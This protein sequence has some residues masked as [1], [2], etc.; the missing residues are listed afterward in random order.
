[1]SKSHELDNAFSVFCALVEDVGYALPQ[2]RSTLSQDV[3]RL[4]QVS[5]NRGLRTFCVD[6]PSLAKHLDRCVANGLLVPS[7]L[8]LGGLKKGQIPLFLGCLY[9]RIFSEDGCLLENV[10]VDS[11]RF[12]RQLLLFAKK[13]KQPFSQQA[14]DTAVSSLFSDDED[15]PK[16]E[17]FWQLANPSTCLMRNTYRGFKT[18]RWYAEKGMSQPEAV[19][20]FMSTLDSVAALITST[21][22][23]FRPEDWRCKHGPGAISQRSGRPNKYHWFGWSS[24]L[25]SVY[26][27]ADYG[28]H[29]YASWAWKDELADETGDYTP[30]SRLVAVPKT[31]EKPRLIAA[32]PGESQWC[33]QN[34]WHYFDDR[35][36]HSWI[37]EFL[38]FRDQSLNQTLCL[39]GSLDG[40]L[41]TIDLSAASDRV[42][43]HVVG[44]FFRSNLDLLNALRAT[45]TRYLRQEISGSYPEVLELQ[46][47]S[48]MGSACTFPVESLLFLGIALA[49]VLS[50]RG[51][52]VTREN[53]EQLIGKVAVFGDDIIVPRESRDSLQEYL[54][55]LD[56]KV[57]GSKS[58]S[59]GFFRESCGVDAFKGE[60]VTPVYWHGSCNATPESIVSTVECANNY[61]YSFY[62]H[63]A[64]L[65]ES[66]APSM[67]MTVPVGSGAFGFHSRVGIRAARKRWNGALQREE[68]RCL[69][70]SSKTTVEQPNDDSSLHQYFTERPSPLDE[71]Q[72]GVRK[73]SEVI[74]KPRWVAEDDILT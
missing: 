51:M 4:R 67:I 31:F 46:K 48:T 6:L 56:F 33:Q 30:S 18:S 57:N 14:L 3:G 52:A 47:F 26:P 58:F 65:L 2:L 36:A 23:A 27:I 25:E 24:S 28:F 37:S 22:G 34:I 21:L 69:S 61:Y 5:S 70:P 60:C 12:L 64:M 42:S 53:V 55:I 74:M 40:S 54:E 45:R 10:C 8:P 68:Y 7:N 19:S 16:P 73:R 72:S 15:L 35:V 44:H 66:T 1:M 41:A 11:Y 17:L 50:D 63:T 49:T 62:L 13:W 32:E 39:K 59:E 20:V 38:R 9:E 43:C 71:W 29:S